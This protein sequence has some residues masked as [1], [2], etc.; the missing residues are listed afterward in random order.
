MTRRRRSRRWR[1]LTRPK[2]TF[3]CC[4]KFLKLDCLENFDF[5]TKVCKDY[6][7]GNYGLSRE[8]DTAAVTMF[9]E[10]ML[11]A[12]KDRQ[13][14]APVSQDEEIEVLLVYLSI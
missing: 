10:V 4:C 3:F 12:L 2:G 5:D 7:R 14:R 11:K 13:L 1:Q 6:E 8:V 9:A